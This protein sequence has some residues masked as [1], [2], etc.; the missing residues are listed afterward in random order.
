VAR[1]RVSKTTVDAAQP[2]DRDTLYWDDRLAG[3]GLKVTPTGRKVY[4]YRYRVA[5]P[6]EAAKTTPIT[7]TIGTHGNV[8]PDEARKLAGALAG[9]VAEGGNPQTEKAERKRTSVVDA[10]LAF[11]RRAELWLEHYEHEKARRPSSVSQ[12]NLVVRN[13]LKPALKDRPLPLIGRTDIQSIIDKIPVQQK[14]MRRAVFAYASV[15][16]GWAASR[17]DIPRNPLIEMAKPDAPK[18][19]DRTLSDNELVSVWRASEETPNPFGA[20]YRLLI[21]TGQRR[22]EVASMRWDD[23]DRKSATWTIPAEK[24]KNGQVHLV[25]LAGRVIEEL[26]AL[27][28]GEWPREGYVLTTTGKNPISGFSKAK[29]ALDTRIAGGG[30][31]VADWRVH[32]LR[33]TLATGLQRLGVR[34]EVTEAVLNHVSGAKGGVAGIYQRHN[35]LEEKRAALEAWERHFTTLRCPQVQKNILACKSGKF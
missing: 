3:F 29:K 2:G 14:A 18:A 6:G 19:R 8:T 26:D 23:L 22:D 32:D 12:A 31:Q 16:F 11:R 21:L 25:P 24:A 34:F 7:Y 27:A 20:F 28:D 30:E 17:G 9:R 5:R 4:V 1:L 35:W 10:D 15:F 13:H 33:R